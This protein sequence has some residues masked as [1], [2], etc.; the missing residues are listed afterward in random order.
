MGARYVIHSIQ[1]N[2]N[3]C[4]VE[5]TA[6]NATTNCWRVILLVNMIIV[7]AVPTLICITKYMDNPFV[8]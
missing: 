3:P 1:Y 2:L 8:H 5:Q 7:I 4:I 6:S